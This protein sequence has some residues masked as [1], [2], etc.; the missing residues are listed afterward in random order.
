MTIPIY[1][2]SKTKHAWLWQSIRELGVN[3]ISTWIDEA[4][5]GETNDFMSLWL[6]C[7]AEASTCE[8]LLA[9]RASED[10][11]LKGAFIE[12]GAALAM[13]RKVF[14]VGPFQESFVDHPAVHRFDSLHAALREVRRLS[15]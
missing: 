8:V 14:L 3:V 5:V 15:E 2:A 11:I 1:T 7:I 10:E 6:R 4:G 9:Y 13:G 12:I